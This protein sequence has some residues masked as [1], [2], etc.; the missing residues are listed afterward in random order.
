MFC[1]SLTFSKTD[2]IINHLV[3]NK[4][5]HS[6][7]AKV[8]HGY[9]RSFLYNCHWRQVQTLQLLKLVSRL[10]CVSHGFWRVAEERNISYGMK[11]ALE[12]KREIIGVAN[13][14][15]SHPTGWILLQQRHVNTPSRCQPANRNHSL[16]EWTLNLHV[17]LSL[18]VTF[19][20]LVLPA[21]AINFAYLITSQISSLLHLKK[22]E[23]F[24]PLK[25]FG[26]GGLFA[27][28]KFSF[29]GWNP[30]FNLYPGFRTISF[31]LCVSPYFSFD[32]GVFF[33]VM[34]AGTV[35]SDTREPTCL[36]AL[37]YIIMKSKIT[38]QSF[39]VVGTKLAMILFTVSPQEAQNVTL[40]DGPTFKNAILKPHDGHYKTSTFQGHVLRGD[41]FHS[42]RTYLKKVFL[43]RLKFRFLLGN[44]SERVK[45]NTNVQKALSITLP[46]GQCLE[47]PCL[48]NISCSE[49]ERINI[50]ILS[51]NI[52]SQNTH[53]CTFSGIALFDQKSPDLETS[54]VC[55]FYRDSETTNGRSIYSSSSEILAL[56]YWYKSDSEFHTRLHMDTTA[57]QAVYIKPCYAGT[58]CQS[59]GNPKECQNYLESLSLR[60]KLKLTLD[61][62]VN[63]LDFMF[64]TTLSYFPFG[65]NCSLIHISQS[66]NSSARGRLSYCLIHLVLGFTELKNISVRH[67]VRSGYG[68]RSPDCPFRLFTNKGRISFSNSMLAKSKSWVVRKSNHIWHI[69]GNV[70][71]PISGEDMKFWNIRFVGMSEMWHEIVV[72]LTDTPPKFTHAPPG[73]VLRIYQKTKKALLDVAMQGKFHFFWFTGNILKKL[74]ISYNFVTSANSDRSAMLLPKNCFTKGFNRNTFKLSGI[75][76]F[77]NFQ[78]KFPFSFLD[79][80]QLGYF[81]YKEQGNGR[82]IIV[83][84]NKEKYIVLLENRATM[85]SR[86]SNVPAVVGDSVCLKFTNNLEQ[87]YFFMGKI[88]H[89]EMGKAKSSFRRTRTE[90]KAS[91]T[92]KSWYE[93]LLLCHK[94][95]GHLPVFL[96]REELQTFLA[97]IKLSYSFPHIVVLYIGLTQAQVSQL[98][99]LVCF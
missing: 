91:V 74:R 75:M 85:E 67:N 37:S 27:A 2:H 83:T 52:S 32:L 12:N 61:T 79:T 48:M 31:S 84:W 76:H 82:N 87:S 15:S 34:D 30:E 70:T 45:L 8:W 19:Y 9:L 6:S 65:L 41:L 35:G 16:I 66:H 64:G 38:I 99:T 43:S 29:S 71:G 1:C 24:C 80:L 98:D 51:S 3:D 89:L 49:H 94:L 18:N 78:K 11:I 25:A 33:K 36:F 69:Q 58:V 54:L 28:N 81:S 59:Y 57:C 72:Q 26:T 96:S 73:Q 92:R 20:E 60:S 55:S 50:T 56:V 46:G 10:E 77:S 93:A 90:M 23:M 4:H 68:S 62:T 7:D 40:F 63:P 44:I 14:V 95:G 13:A 47:N 22:S 88:F 21:A 39:S 42:M 86:C 5:I 97:M 53:F 17:M